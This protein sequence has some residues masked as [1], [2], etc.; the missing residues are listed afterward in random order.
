MI[1]LSFCNIPSYHGLSRKCCHQ[2][3][4][5]NA[6]TVC[7]FR[8]SQKPHPVIK[9]YKP[10]Y[11]NN[12]PIEVLSQELP[13]EIVCYFSQADGFPAKQDA[14]YILQHRQQI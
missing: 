6:Y 10:N 13:E 8:I 1:E 3:S 12:S 7:T 2:T 5:D 4:P 11:S 9:I 14:R